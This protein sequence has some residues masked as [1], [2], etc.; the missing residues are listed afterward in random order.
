MSLAK[1]LV[2]LSVSAAA[3]GYT[4]M[5]TV[6]AAVHPGPD[7]LQIEG[8]I[9]PVQAKPKG[10]ATCGAYMYWSAKEN[11]CMDARLKKK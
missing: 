7:A 3:L 6:H 1:Q 5:P 9:V 10:K 4:L 2:A 11:K 8:L